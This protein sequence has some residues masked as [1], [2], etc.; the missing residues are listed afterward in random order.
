M[1][2]GTFKNPTV[3][4]RFRDFERVKM[5]CSARGANADPIKRFGVDGFP[6]VVVLDKTGKRLGS[7]V[8]AEPPDA[9]L[10]ELDGILKGG[11]DSDRDE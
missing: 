7:I 10:Q 5:D 8:G 1:D 2:A 6:T 4:Q 11:G 9:F 3:A